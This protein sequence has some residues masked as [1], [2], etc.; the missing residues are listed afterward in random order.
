[1]WLVYRWRPD[2]RTALANGVAVGLTLLA[3]G[4]AASVSPAPIVDVFIAWAVGHAA[5]SLALAWRV[6]RGPVEPPSQRGVVLDLRRE[7]SARDRTRR[8]GGLSDSVD[9][10]EH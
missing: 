1:M 8:K 9:R 3:M 7:R 6:G 2:R 10:T 5:W 4:M